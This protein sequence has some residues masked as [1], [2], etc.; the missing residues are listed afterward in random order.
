MAEFAA[1]WAVTGVIRADAAG[2][3]GARAASNRIRAQGNE[4]MCEGH[5]IVLRSGDSER[6]LRGKTVLAFGRELR[7]I[8]IANGPAAVEALSGR[9]TT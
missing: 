1:E 9:G 4:L 7:V 8:R 3:R 5:G 6:R 2:M